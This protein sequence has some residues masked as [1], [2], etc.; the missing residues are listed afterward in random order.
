MCVNGKMI[1]VETIPGLREREDEG[2]WWR[3]QIQVQYIGYIVRTFANATI[4][5]HP[6]QCKRRKIQ[7]N[8]NFNSGSMCS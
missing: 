6:E 2:K 3:G 7:K 5:P 8:K 4:Y 1:S